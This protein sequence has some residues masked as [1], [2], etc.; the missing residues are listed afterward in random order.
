[1]LTADVVI[2]GAGPV[3]AV[4]AYVLAE[5]GVKVVLC[6]A[7]GGVPRGYAGLNL[8]SAHTGDSR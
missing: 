7:A 4:A 3:G 5:K 6:E 8:S 1:M 2:V